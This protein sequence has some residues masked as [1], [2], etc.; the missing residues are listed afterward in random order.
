MLPRTFQPP[1][2]LLL[3]ILVR[4]LALGL[5]LLVSVAGRF[6]PPY[7]DLGSISLSH[8]GSSALG[9]HSVVL[10]TRFENHG[11]L[12]WVL[13]SDSEV[14][15]LGCRYGVFHSSFVAPVVVCLVPFVLREGLGALRA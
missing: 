8:S 6:S 15:D 3:M 4:D 9:P 1:A 5:V 10:R 14:L 12:L 11:Y 13:H 2:L 7:L